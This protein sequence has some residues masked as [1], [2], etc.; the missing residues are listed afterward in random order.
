MLRAI[1][2]I[3]KYHLSRFSLIRLRPR[4]KALCYGELFPLRCAIDKTRQYINKFY[5]NRRWKYGGA[6]IG[7]RH[8]SVHLFF[9]HY[10]TFAPENFADA[11]SRQTGDLM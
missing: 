5:F 1:V 3:C 9:E 4:E 2:S 7:Q 10:A 11:S 6:V 8:N